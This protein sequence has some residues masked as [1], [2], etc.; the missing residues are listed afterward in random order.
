MGKRSTYFLLG[1][2]FGA[3]LVLAISA[4][5]RPRYWG[6]AISPAI[7][8]CISCGTIVTSIAER[9]GKVKSIGELRHPL[10]LFPHRDGPHSS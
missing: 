10:T 2:A 8:F 6:F 7:A 1:F 9:K 3:L 4:I 5:R